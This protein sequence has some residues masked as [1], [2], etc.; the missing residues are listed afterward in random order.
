MSVRSQRSGFLGE[1]LYGF[2]VSIVAAAALAALSLILPLQTV[3]RILIAVIGLTVSLRAIRRSNEKT[4]RIVV[5]AIWGAMAAGLWTMGVELS[6]YAAAH[7]GMAW[8]VR[9]LFSYSR[10]I[11]AGLDLG[12]TFVAVGFALIAE[13][14]TESVFLACWSF[15]LVQALHVGIPQIAGRWNSTGEGLPEPDPNREFEYAYRAA[16]EAVQRI[17]C[18]G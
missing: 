2:G 9:S 13:A 10:L 11:E 16:D 6:F 5:L 4:G 15:L 14:R 7:V 3:V 18:R 8:L 12:L 1:A 17:A